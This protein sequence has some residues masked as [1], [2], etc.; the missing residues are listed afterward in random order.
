MESEPRAIEAAVTIIMPTYNRA[1]FIAEAID[2]VVDQAFRDWKLL[3]V[4][5][6]STDETRSVVEP[7][8]KRDGRIDYVVQDQNRGIAF[9]R[10]NGVARSTGPYIAMLDSDDAWASDEKLGLQIAAL[11]ADPKLGIVGTWFEIID[12]KGM[13]TGVRKSFPEDDK[14]IR[15]KEIYRNAFAQSSVVFRREAFVKAGG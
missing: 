6:G 4:D 13:P 9:T 11:E 2:S 8:L 3:I 5:D 14:G 7:Y 15:A 10:N 12:E 1:G